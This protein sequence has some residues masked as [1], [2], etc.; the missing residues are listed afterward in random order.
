MSSTEP[1][2]CTVRVEPGQDHIVFTVISN[3]FP[4][5]GFRPNRRGPST[6]SVDPDVALAA[7]REFLDSF[8]EN[9]GSS[10]T[11]IK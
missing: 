5:H 9:S 11:E 1:G 8:T 3:Y 4:A 6:R 2:V 10:A 7:V